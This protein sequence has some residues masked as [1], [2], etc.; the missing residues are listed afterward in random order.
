V[1]SRKL[2]ASQ[3]N[4]AKAF[5][6]KLN[7]LRALVT[8]KPTQGAAAAVAAT[9]GA[10]TPGLPSSSGESSLQNGG[11]SSSLLVPWNNGGGD[12]DDSDIIV[13]GNTT[14]QVVAVVDPVRSGS[15]GESLLLSLETSYEEAK[16]ADSKVKRGGGGGE[17]G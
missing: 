11:K 16:A 5:G 9:V 7:D 3:A 2:S 8:V 17:G 12:N 6:A 4:A 10:A 15:F 13:D 14:T 1:L